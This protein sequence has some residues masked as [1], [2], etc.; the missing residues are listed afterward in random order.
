MQNIIRLL[1]YR[2]NDLTTHFIS[3]AY[4]FKR[5]ILDLHQIPLWSPFQFM[6]QPYIADPQNYIF[7]LPHYLLVLLPVEPAFLILIFSHLTW[8]GI[9]TYFLA[10][11]QFHL[12]KLPSIFAALAF[13]LTPKLFAHLEGGHY[14]ML[15]A[16]SW[17]PWFMLT[18]FK[19]TQKPSLK[20]ACLLSIFTWILYINYVNIAYFALLFF[21][22][23]TVYYFFAHR[24]NFPFKKFFILHS[25]FFILFLSLI[26]PNLFAQLEFAELSTRK[27]MNFEYVAQPIWSFKLFL[28]NL[29]FPYRLTYLQFTTE[30][31]LFPGIIIGALSI[32]GFFNSKNKTRWFFAGWMVFSLLFSLGARIPFFIFFYKYF[33]LIK[34][35]RITTRIWIISNILIALFAGVGIERLKRRFTP[36]MIYLIIFLSL[37]ELSFVQYKIFGQPTQPDLLPQSF[38]RYLEQ[39]P[40]SNFRTY[41]TSGCFSLQKLGELNINSL[42]G[43]NPLQ[44][45][46]YVNFL[47]TGAG[48]QYWHY[49]PILPPYQTLN[50]K[51]QPKSGLMG[52]LNAK[53]IASPYPLTDANFQLLESNNGFYLYLNTAH[54]SAWL[55]R[56]G[57]AKVATYSPNKITAE[58]STSTDNTLVL[59]EVFYPGWKAIDQNNHPLQIIDAHPFRAV[60]ISPDTTKVTFSYWPSSLTITL[61]IFFTALGFIIYANRDLKFFFWS[62]RTRG[63][64]SR[65]RIDN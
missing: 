45:I 53:Y 64:S 56:E 12:S 55:A 44:L 18:A 1:L 47:Q 42:S 48:Y 27:L 5:S 24:K 13:A 7:Y 51:P 32:L 58:V 10:K 37:A 62:S 21:A 28:Q 2:G 25:S 26:S 38:Y 22:S 31:I 63:R 49:A 8:A 30:R 6:G 50:Q 3:N 36:K 54:N 33:P 14:S 15:L 29:L 35:M 43:N 19:F 9:G 17:L 52:S 4:F 60:N 40:Q 46:S 39:D 41:C 34:W 57:I 59:S 23:Y 20:L 61:P 65:R 16:F 11:N